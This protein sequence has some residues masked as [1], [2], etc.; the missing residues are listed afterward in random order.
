MLFFAN[1]SMIAHE[2]KLAKSYYYERNVYVNL[3]MLARS[4]MCCHSSKQP[5]RAASL[6]VDLL[7]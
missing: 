5:H 4:S 6:A 7:K 1:V 2:T 3:L